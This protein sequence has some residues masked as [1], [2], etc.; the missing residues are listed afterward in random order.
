MTTATCPPDTYVPCGIPEV[1]AS[2]VVVEPTV[3]HD[4]LLATTGLDGSVW[5][6]IAWGVIL[7]GA[8]GLVTASRMIRAGRERSKAG[9]A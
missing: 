8:A 3:V 4:V 2:S 6:L 5:S 1:P 7:I 9:K